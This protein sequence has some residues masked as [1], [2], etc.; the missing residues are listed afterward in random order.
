[1]M[2][3]D[4][5][6]MIAAQPPR[7][8]MD[9]GFLDVG[10]DSLFAYAYNESNRCQRA[11]CPTSLQPQH[12]EAALRWYQQMVQRDRMPDVSSLSPYEREEFLLSKQSARRHA[13]I[14]VDEPVLY[15]N[16]LL[17]DGIGVA[18]FPGLD[19]FDG[20]T[21]LW[22]DGNFISAGSERP[23]AVWQWLSFLSQAPPLT[24]F[25]R[26]PAR[27]SIATQTGFWLALPR[28]LADPMRA[29]FNSAR[30]VTIEDKL[31]FLPEQVTAVTTSNLSPAAA[32]NNQ[33]QINW[34]S[35]QQ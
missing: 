5:A 16:H 35:N 23:Y 4:M 11:N 20:T 14:W 32:A 1:V 19:L 22:V 13:A 29:A 2:E 12:I 8:V 26:I 27:P 21:P 9:W 7:S 31:L 3:D 15:E 30:P 10:R 28:Q 17:L 18:P 34:L 24:G 25:R 33:P 6:A